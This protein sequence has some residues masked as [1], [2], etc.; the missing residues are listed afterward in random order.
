MVKSVLIVDDDPTQRRLLQAVIEK[1]GYRVETAE[2]GDAALDRVAAS[3]VDVMLLDLIMP[4]MDGMETLEAVKKRL[5]DLPVIVLTASGGIETVVAAMRAGALDFFVKPASPERIA[6]SIRN[7]LKVQNLSGEVQRLTRKAA[8]M[9]GFADMIAEAAAMQQVVRLGERA[10]QSDIPILVTGESGVGKE[11]VAQSIMAASKRAGGPF[12]AVNCGAIP[13]NLVE[14]TLFGHEK[15]SFTGATGKHMGKF[16]EADGGTLFL[17]EVGELP[18]DMQVKL[19]RALQEGEVDPVGSKRPVKV[20]TRIISA[21]NRDLTERVAAGAFREDLF[22]RLNVFPIEVPSLRSRRD[23]VPALVRHFIGRFNA[24]E[25]KAIVDASPETHAMLSS[26]DWPGNVRQLENAVFRAVIL[27]DGDYLTPA[28][29]P[30]ISGLVPNVQSQTAHS[31]EI[32]PAAVE[33][34]AG[35]GEAAPVEI[36]DAG[37]NL[38]S[39]EDIERDLIEFAIETYAGRMSEVARRL[40]VGRST[41]YRKVR[42]Y[43]LDVDGVRATG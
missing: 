29:F 38:R 42:E 28:D 34:M 11:L 6:V 5:P 41:L 17:D 33:L 18:L 7:A 12:V 27:A 36:M 10:A 32:S 1:Q 13:E 30:Q 4:G 3:P 22:Y 20:N 31:G 8:N 39:L 19:L 23:D 2:S 43:D 16:Q 35:S 15:G 25:G 37:G 21:T 26:F 14:S 40:G 24:Q 9:S